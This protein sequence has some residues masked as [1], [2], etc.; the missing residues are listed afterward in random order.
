MQRAQAWV[1]AEKVPSAQPWPVVVLPPGVSLPRAQ[2]WVLAEKE[3]LAQALVHLV[4]VEEAAQALSQPALIGA[5]THLV[6]VCCCE[7]EVASCWAAVA[8]LPPSSL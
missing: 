7:A 1:L 8:L 3:P 4:L 2:A 5:A 6:S